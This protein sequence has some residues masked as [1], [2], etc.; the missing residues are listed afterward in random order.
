MK[1]GFSTLGCPNW[2]LSEIL[3]TAKD[4]G[5][6]GVE[7]RGIASE[8]YAPTM[9]CFVQ[10]QIDKTIQKLGNLEIPI[11]TSNA[12]IATKENIDAS[13]KEAMEYIELAGK[14][15]AKY[16]RIMSTARAMLDDGDYEL[17]LGYYKA[18]AK[19]GEKF[20]VT[21][22]MET[23]GMF[24]D[25]SLLSKFMKDTGESNIGVLWDIHHPYRYNR[26][27]IEETLK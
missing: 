10:D 15:G 18:L 8:M 22:L 9:K 26:E 12:T 14:I 19:H 16:V 6:N 24:C 3:A 25:T 21:P 20:G 1:I 27:T 5:Y 2:T 23:N 11:L 13:I 4:L 7:I 17:A